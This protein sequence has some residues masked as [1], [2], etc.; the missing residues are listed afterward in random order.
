[1]SNLTA[2]ESLFRLFNVDRPGD[3]YER[4]MSVSDVIILQQGKDTPQAYACAAF[5][6]ANLKMTDEFYELMQR[7][8]AIVTECVICK[9]RFEFAGSVDAIERLRQGELIQNV[10][11]M[12]TDAERELFISG[13]C[14]KCWDKT[15]KQ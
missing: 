9:T 13:I 14:G 10:F 8:I 6:F 3:Y 11:P 12:L 2:L 15:V 7:T 1:M 4:S 5:G